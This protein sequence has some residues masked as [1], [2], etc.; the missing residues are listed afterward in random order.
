MN[1][2]LIIGQFNDVTK[3]LSES[4]SQYC[5]VQICADNDLVVKNMIRMLEPD[6][7]IV[8]LI[9]T[10]GAHE[11]IFAMLTR[12]A[13]KTPVIAVGTAEIEMALNRVGC[14]SDGRVRFLR[15][16]IKLEKVVAQARELLPDREA[17]KKKL[18]HILV[19][20]DSPTLL[21]TMQ[22][23]LSK[24]Y[25]VTFA[26]SGPQ[27]IMAISRSRPDLILLDYDMPVCDGRMTLQMLRSEKT[28]RDIPVVFLTGMSD[29]TYVGEVLALH[30]QGY[31]LK[32]PS[33]TK[34]MSTLRN[35]LGDGEDSESDN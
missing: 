1:K 25:K 10:E 9:G 27:A 7:V 14:L 30:P 31:L 11:E 34:I 2:A 21:R 17:P 23:M 4:L 3:H 20:D 28:T 32:P 24:Q 5:Q 18:K 13:F 35:I 29:P 12:E 15:R 33:E 6:L 19:V 22:N 26:T 16:P 8:L